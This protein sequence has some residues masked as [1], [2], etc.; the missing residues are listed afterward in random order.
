MAAI[1]TPTAIVKNADSL[2]FKMWQKM[3]LSQI[4]Y[5]ITNFQDVWLAKWVTGGTLSNRK[6]R[7]TEE[8]PPHNSQL[9][10]K[11]RDNDGPS[12]KDKKIYLSFRR[13]FFLTVG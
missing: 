3:L 12:Y 11:E 13:L 5:Y 6:K 2:V 7:K 8:S 10:K 4:H 1:L 9:L